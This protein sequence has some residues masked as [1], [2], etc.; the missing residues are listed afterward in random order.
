MCEACNLHLLEDLS[1]VKQNTKI[2]C[3]YPSYNSFL[4]ISHWII[5]IARPYFSKKLDA[6]LLI[7]YKN[8]SPPSLQFFLRHSLLQF[9]K[10]NELPPTPEFLDASKQ[11]SGDGNIYLSGYVSTC[12]KSKK[13]KEKKKDTS[14]S[15][16]H[17]QPYTLM[18]IH[19]ALESMC[20]T[21][22]M[23]QGGP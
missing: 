14:A 2:L 1:A 9:L 15:Q 21:V 20:E 4:T 12:S 6:D 17:C 22:F 16:E 18:P 10:T 7:I 8:A 19:Y 11:I 23:T 5:W 13:K 3:I